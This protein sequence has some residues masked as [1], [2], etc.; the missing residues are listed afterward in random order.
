[1]PTLQIA[2][3][4]PEGTTVE[5][6]GIEGAGASAPPAPPTASHEAVLRYWRALSN[7]GRKLY[8]A[9]ARIEQQHG[10]GFTFEDIAANLSITHSSV[11][12]VYRNVCRTATAWVRDSGASEP[13]IRL[14]DIDYPQTASGVGRRTRYQL[15]PGVADLIADLPLVHTEG[16]D[17]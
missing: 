15:P 16:G 13:P 5:I 8:G 17:A 6:T 10:V 3:T 11:L 7:N 1:M 2:L 14:V 4:V 12:A 9:A